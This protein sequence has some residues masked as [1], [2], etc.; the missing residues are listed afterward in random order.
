MTLKTNFLGRL[1]MQKTLIERAFELANSGRCDTVGDIRRRLKQEGYSGD[2][3]TGS[4]ILAQLRT[5]IK[6]RRGSQHH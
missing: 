1:A 5:I 2:G 4:S 3:L 6:G